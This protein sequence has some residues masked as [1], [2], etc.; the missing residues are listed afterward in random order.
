MQACCASGHSSYIGT[1]QSK[2]NAQDARAQ[3][4]ELKQQIQDAIA[5]GDTQKAQELKAKLRS[6]HQ[7]N[8]Q[9]KQQDK[10][11]I[12]DA[13]QELQQDKKA[14]WDNLTPEERE[15]IKAHHKDLDNNPPGPAGGPGTNWENPPGPKG[16]PGASPDRRGR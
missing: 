6:I 16:G 8:V 7:E 13:R 10:K 1:L 12:R 11:E 14:G 3:E 2:Q 15:K 5:A 4:K 9:Q